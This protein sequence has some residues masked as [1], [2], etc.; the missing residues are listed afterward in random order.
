MLCKA[1]CYKCLFKALLTLLCRC[2]HE[3]QRVWLHKIGTKNSWAVTPQTGSRVA[4]SR[5]ENIK[6]KRCH[7]T[8][9]TSSANFDI[10]PASPYAQTIFHIY[11][12]KQLTFTFDQS[13][14]EESRPQHL[15]NMAEEVSWACVA[16]SKY[17]SL[18]LIV[19]VTASRACKGSVPRAA[20][21]RA[22]LPVLVRHELLDCVKI[23][24]YTFNL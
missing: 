12:I 24:A 21:Y 16:A 7:K 5:E 19:D 3:S 22:R 20:L 2:S 10:Y 17:G 15:Q 11:H 8:G 13:K 23:T 1:S 6:E 14:W 18:V 9:N 4:F